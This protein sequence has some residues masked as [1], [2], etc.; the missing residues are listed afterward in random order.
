MGV[1][2]DTFYR[3]Q[4]AVEQGGVE[5]LFKKSQCKANPKNRGDEQTEAAFFCAQ[6]HIN[7]TRGRV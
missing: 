1:A 4:D 3:Y 2:L 5:A 6:L 7:Y